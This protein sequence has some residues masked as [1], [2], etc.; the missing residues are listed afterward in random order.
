MSKPNSVIELYY[1]SSQTTS[2]AENV[3]MGLSVT[4]KAGTF[5]GC[6]RVRE[7][8]PLDPGAESEKV[9]CPG[10]GLV[11]DDELEL[12]DYGFNIVNVVGRRQR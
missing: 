1:E 9:Y 12:V 11:V 10:V 7:T 6:V 4:T 8:T 5:D 3:E 2:R